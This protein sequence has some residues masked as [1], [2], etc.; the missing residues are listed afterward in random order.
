MLCCARF[1]T[2]GTVPLQPCSYT[3]Y[4]YMQQLNYLQYIGK[5]TIGE[6]LIDAD[7]ARSARIN[8]ASDRCSLR[9]EFSRRLVGG[10]NGGFAQAGL[11]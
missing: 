11:P 8:V 4:E 1:A 2:S 6:I 3:A 7:A 9:D 5:S 10:G